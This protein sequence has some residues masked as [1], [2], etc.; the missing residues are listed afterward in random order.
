VIPTLQLHARWCG[1]FLIAGFVVFFVGAAGWLPAE[2]EARPLPEMLRHVAEREGRWLWIHIWMAAGVIISIAG[3]VA[4]TE[5][6]RQSGERLMTPIASNLFVVGAVLWLLAMALRVTVG[7]WAAREALAGS[8]PAIYPSVHRL[9][10]SLHGAHMAL[11]YVTF[12]A[13]GYGVLRSGIV[14]ALAGWIG[15]AA[16]A[17]GV[18]AFVGLRIGLLGMPFLALTYPFA[19]GVLLLRA[20]PPP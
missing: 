18:I 6:Q 4:W 15:I 11:S 1:W 5:L 8:M 2:F 19:L 14:P 10:G 12:I 3:L 13:L 7:V 16:G 9:A 17:V 20:V